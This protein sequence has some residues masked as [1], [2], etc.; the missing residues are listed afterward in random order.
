[1]ADG[2]PSDST[3]S[4]QS[5]S[6]KSMSADNGVYIL[7]TYGPEFR[8]A[9]AQAIDNIYGEFSDET[10]HWEGNLDA[11]HSVFGKSRVFTDIE[12]AFD[13]AQTMSFDYDYLEDGVCLIQDFA[14]TKF[15]K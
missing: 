11:M 1:M 6:G 10:L 9:Y 15:D 3:P 14:E 13:A 7:Q 4:S 12:D 2:D 5:L 8:V